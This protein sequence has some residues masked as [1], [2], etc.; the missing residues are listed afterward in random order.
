MY[1]CNEMTTKREE[2]LGQPNST[3]WRST[4]QE[5]SQL[6]WNWWQYPKTEGGRSDVSHRV[7]FIYFNKKTQNISTRLE[8][9]LYLNDGYMIYEFCLFLEMLFCGCFGFG[10]SKKITFFKESGTVYFNICPKVQTL[11]ISL[12]NMQIIWRIHVYIKYQGIHLY[13]I[14]KKNN[15]FHMLSYF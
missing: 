1:H 11:F 8:L 6:R 4:G 2:K 7:C 3:W 13:R 15:D 14:F 5:R 10:F 12:E 9:T